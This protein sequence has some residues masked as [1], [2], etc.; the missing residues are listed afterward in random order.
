MST[1]NKIESFSGDFRFLSNF[2]PCTINFE[3][4]IFPSVE[5]A[6]QAAKT[7]DLNTREE[8]R[9]A[10]TPGIAK[11][12]GKKVEL[13]KDWNLVKISVMKTCLL[14]KFSD[15]TLKF[16]LLKTTPLY[17]EEG[18]NWGD[19]FWGICNGVGENNLGKLLM[20]IRDNFLIF[21]F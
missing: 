14:Q 17:L 16:K 4:L 18:N 8:I 19:V 7:L 20:Q 13:R 10:K 21:D 3:G 12:L 9:I 1:Q 5:H 15:E 6:Y 11:K 2:W